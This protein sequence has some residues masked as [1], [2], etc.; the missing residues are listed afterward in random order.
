MN[1]GYPS[2]DM[3]NCQITKNNFLN[4]RFTKNNSANHASQEYPCKT[5]MER[6]TMSNPC[7]FLFVQVKSD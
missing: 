6:D 5:L 2:W 3:K 7:W 1:I 4:S